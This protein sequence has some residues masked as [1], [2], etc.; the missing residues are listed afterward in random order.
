MATTPQIAWLC[1][2]W[3]VSKTRIV[4]RDGYAW[5]D[6]RLPIGRWLHAARLGVHSVLLGLVGAGAI[7]AAPHSGWSAGQPGLG[8]DGAQIVSTP[9]A[10]VAFD[11]RRRFATLIE[12]STKRQ[13]LYGVGDILPDPKGSDS[14][15]RITHIEEQRLQLSSLRGRRAIWIGVGDAVPGRPGWRVLGTPM[16]RL[17]EYRYVRTSGPLDSE[18]RVVE[19]AEDRV[20]LDVDIPL[21]VSASPATRTPARAS[22][23][24]P[25]QSP[26]AGRKFENT[27]LGRVRVKPTADDSYEINAADLNAALEKGV[28][29]FAEAWPRV[30]PSASS[31]RGVSLDIQS[32]IADG[33]LGPRGFRVTSPNLA[34]RGGVQVGDLIVGVNG[35]PV[36]GFADVYRVYSQMQRDPNLSVIQLD[37]VR[38]GQHLTKTYRVR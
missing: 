5:R 37:L 1:A 20:R 10:E 30:W 22:S 6:R 17:V 3:G 27:L 26:E 38:Q 21:T 35:Q 28:Q 25:P 15:Y 24:P 12:P 29:L 31:Q 23:L 7:L 2:L 19:L 33:T 18:P 4:D 11:T 32:P 13:R 36:N 16:L 14:E 9:S 8:D 34:E